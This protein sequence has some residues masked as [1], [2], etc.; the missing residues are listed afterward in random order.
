MNKH[1]QTLLDLMSAP[2]AVDLCWILSRG[3]VFHHV[4]VDCQ[5]YL[6]VSRPQDGLSTTL[7]WISS[8]SGSLMWKMTV[9]SSNLLLMTQHM[10]SLAEMPA[11][12]TTWHSMMV[13]PVL[14]HLL[15]DTVLLIPHLPR[16]PPPTKP[17]L[18]SRPALVLTHP[19]EWVLEC[20]MRQSDLV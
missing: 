8:A 2:V 17:W 15:G 4:A 13:R 19:T 18:C 10:G 14:P 5:P 3:V 9:I 16:Y 7:Q 1:V 12:Q 11:L 6:A 20:L